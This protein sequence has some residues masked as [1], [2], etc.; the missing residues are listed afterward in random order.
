MSS[1]V[2]TN[3]GVKFPLR[4]SGKIGFRE[5]FKDFSALENINL[6]LA[7]EDRVALLGRNGAGKTTLLKV[8]AGILPP[9]EGSVEVHGRLNVA[10]TMSLGLLNQASCIEN[11]RLAG[12]YRGLAGKKLNEF[13]DE[14]VDR[15][16]L[17]KFMYQPLS[18]LSKGMRSKLVVAVALVARSEILIFDEWIGAIDRQQMLGQNALAAAIK[19]SDIFVVATHKLGIVEKYCN[20]CLILEQGSIIEDLPTREAIQFYNEHI[21]S[22]DSH[23]A[24][25]DG[26]S[27]DMS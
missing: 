10:L 8:M 7:S 25:D 17:R 19:D 5:K 24:S 23:D 11:I 21:S 1:L 15:A 13:Q 22:E 9:T 3:V 6:H 18:T 16:D 12:Y 14:V 4:T 27:D 2:L 20:R 26:D